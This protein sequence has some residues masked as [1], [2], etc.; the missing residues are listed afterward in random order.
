MHETPTTTSRSHKTAVIFFMRF[1]RLRSGIV[2]EL[3]EKPPV[4]GTYIIW[5]HNII[6]L[7]R[8]ITTL[9][10][11]RISTHETVAIRLYI[12]RQPAGKRGWTLIRRFVNHVFYRRILPRYSRHKTIRV[13]SVSNDPR[14]FFLLCFTRQ[15]IK[16]TP[17][18]CFQIGQS[19]FSNTHHHHHLK[20]YSCRTRV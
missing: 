10:L 2:F 19:T 11:C 7:V 1:P 18:N 20:T 5:P 8:L 17:I 3:N 13:W 9:S 15:R 6:I 14:F 12:I 16:G 4:P